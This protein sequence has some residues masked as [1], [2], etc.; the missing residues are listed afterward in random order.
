M[1]ALPSGC[2]PA[3]PAAAFVMDELDE[4]LKLR[5]L[6]KAARKCSAGS[7]W[8]SGTALYRWDALEN[9]VKLQNAFRDGTYKL[10]RYQRF[11]ITRPKPRQIT[12][13]RIRD[14]HIQRSACDNVL[15][16]RLTRSFI[17][18]NGACQ[19]GKGVD[20]EL[21]RVKCGLQHM[22][23]QQ[24]QQR[25]EA[26]GCRPEDVPPFEIEG[27]V[28]KGD[29][30]KYFPSTL[31]RNAKAIL[32]RAVASPRLRAM[33]CA[34]VES[35]GQDWWEAQAITAGAPVAAAR[36]FARAITDARTEREM[37]PIRPENQRAAIA[38]KCEAQIRQ[39]V[40]ALRGI[41][42]KARAQLCILA[43]SDEVRGIGLGSQ[44]SQLVQ[45]AQLNAIDH[46]ATEVAHVDLYY[47]YMDDYLI[48]DAGR[49]K[50]K[51][52]ARNIAQMLDG[53][54]LGENPKS[55]LIQ[56]R[57]GFIFL[58]WHISVTPTGK[59]LMKP[60]PEVIKNEKRRLRRMVRKVAEGKAT[61]D[62]V[63]VHYQGWRAHMER[64]D[65]GRQLENMDKYLDGL[66]AAIEKGGHENEHQHD[67]RT[68][69]R[70]CGSA[71]QT[72]DQHHGQRPS[73]V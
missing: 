11:D 57:D 37:L 29:V 8:K 13:T 28:Y 55:Q 65:T 4:V 58:K 64:G 66:L 3:I 54:G 33:F 15:Y 62:S 46:Y 56:L 70:A 51:N 17:H 52:A 60:A 30:K 69:P 36:I 45:L 21:N 71:G 27:W 67:Q 18:N 1:Q 6:Y 22:Y 12:A 59:V 73:H 14:R 72:P 32:R 40:N 34:V 39:A 5:N 9:S 35:F 49:E 2:V 42:S 44:M 10:Q 47:R 61:V 63:R 53:L 31:H 43:N 16:A 48:A 68:A 41:T 26:M 24:R 7:M 38:R 50:P 23:R 20:F 19:V 25:A